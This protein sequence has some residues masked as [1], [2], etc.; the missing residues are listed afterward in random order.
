MNV[1][2]VTDANSLRLSVFIFFFGH[3]I[4]GNDYDLCEKMQLSHHLKGKS[5]C[6]KEMLNEKE[7]RKW[8]GVNKIGISIDFGPFKYALK[9]IDFIFNFFLL[10]SIIEFKI[11]RNIWAIPYVN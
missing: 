3:I 9:L 1:N 10:N 2:L 11:A 4:A 8:F 6:R 7:I 5:I